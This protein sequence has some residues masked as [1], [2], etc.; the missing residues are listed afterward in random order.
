[1]SVDHSRKTHVIHVSPFSLDESQIFFAL[2]GMAHAANLW[3]CFLQHLY[4]SDHAI[5]FAAYC[6]ALTMFW[7]PVHRHRLPEIPHRISCSLGCGF[8]SRS[9]QADMIIPGV[10]NP[11]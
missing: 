11:H 4:F 1:M 2:Y 6:T 9:A 8:F 10:Q 5:L 3:R 7:Y